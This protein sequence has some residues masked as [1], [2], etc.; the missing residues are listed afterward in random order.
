MTEIKHNRELGNPFPGL[1]PFESHEAH[2]FFGRDGQSDQLLGKLS[3]TRFVAVIGTSGSGKS[4]LVRAG[5]LPALY[6]GITVTG[7]DWHVGVLRPGGDPM[8]NLARSLISPHRIKSDSRQVNNE[9]DLGVC[10][11][12]LRRSSTG[13]IEARNWLKTVMEASPANM[14]I[15]VDQ[16]EELFRYKREA[17]DNQTEDV[18]AAFVKLLL[19]AVEH[20]DVPIYVVLTMRSEYL[21]DCAQFLGLPEAIN[22]GQYLIPRLTRDERRAAIEGPIGVCHSKISQFLVNR[23]LND[24]GDNPK[25]LPILQHALM[26]TWDQWV[27]TDQDTIDLNNYY[28]IGGMTSALSRYGDEVFALFSD[29]RQR[30]I[31]RKLFTCLVERDQEGRVVR[32]PTSLHTICQIIHGDSAPESSEKEIFE[33]AREVIPVIETFRSPSVSF[34]TPPPHIKLEAEHLDIV[35]DISHESLIRGWEMLQGWA[36]SE[37]DSARIYRRLAES[38][39]M[40]AAG[41]AALYKGRDLRVA[42][43]WQEDFRPSR[44]WAVRYHPAFDKAM[45]FLRKSRRQRVITI[46]ATCIAIT[47][48]LI[49]I[50]A[51]IF[52]FDRQRNITRSEELAA[53][54]NDISQSDPQRGLQLAVEAVRTYETDNAVKALRQSLVEN[55]SRVPIPPIRDGTRRYGVVSGTFSPNGKFVLTAN[56][57]GKAYI[58][59][60]GTEFGE[61]SQIG[62]IDPKL[63]F[64]TSASFNSGGDKIII[65]AGHAKKAVV[66]NFDQDTY[67]VGSQVADLRGHTGTVN[68]AAFSQDG[69]Y[70]ITAS[71]DGTARIWDLNQRNG[72]QVAV[73]EH[74]PRKQNDTLN[75]QT[76]QDTVWVKSAVF[77]PTDSKYILTASWDGTAR[78]WYWDGLS[79]TGREVLEPARHEG[80]VN[81]AAFSKDGKHIVT[82]GNDRKAKVMEWNQN[83]G[84]VG[85]VL[86]FIHDAPVLDAAFNP[87]DSQ[88]IITACA[89]KEAR[90]WNLSEDNNVAPIKGTSLWAHSDWVTGVSFNQEEHS[91][92]KQLIL[93]TGYD[94]TALVLR[95]IEKKEQL[96][97]YL[98]QALSPVLSV[99]FID[100]GKQF[101]TGSN[102]GSVRLWDVATMGGRPLLKPNPSVVALDAVFS[103]DG[104]RVALALNDGSV[105]WRNI[106]TGKTLI[107][108]AHSGAALSVALSFN[109]SRLASGG[110]D[111]TTKVWDVSDE[112]YNNSMIYRQGITVS[113][114][115]VA[116][117]SQNTH[118]VT[119]SSD[120]ATQLLD[121][122]TGS[123]TTWSQ[124]A[125]IQCVAFSPDGKS[126]VI[127]GNDGIILIIGVEGTRRQRM[128]GYDG[129]KP[130]PIFR[131]KFS[132][133]G[134]YL[135]TADYDS[136]R[137]WDVDTGKQLAKM[138]ETSIDRRF[139]EVSRDN[140]I[141]TNVNQQ[142]SNI[143]QI[144]SD[145]TSLRLI[146][147]LAFSLDDKYITIARA[148][149][150]PVHMFAWSYFSSATELLKKAETFLSR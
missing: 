34:L 24:A 110:R 45:D 39:D 135:A 49:M 117:N 106:D 13:L 83:T 10:E 52:F 12:I 97:R 113:V 131:A 85:K 43:D 4:S 60:I 36:D 62:V 122:Q 144:P 149:D 114:N 29:T 94:G 123:V 22:K 99:S 74:K 17:A 88:N 86:E 3:K 107:I 139:A 87:N 7:S 73:L 128:T 42:S 89:D 124:S 126:I 19:V 81:N 66:W 72:K 40:H 28:A 16:F 145:S 103:G 133:N 15:I 55:S 137:V 93:A 33:V 70:A 56:R 51:G 102:D 6:G 109:G 25:N 14:L 143:T 127:V 96:E 20:K 8:G 2:L 58:W 115:S 98:D 79:P 65:T 68:R 41:K 11:T 142:A 129:S 104:K 147:N 35:I 69:R 112:G 95:Y 76:V 48:V 118:V 38:A 77:S 136:V 108:P 30:E 31:A 90:L 150:R 1:R 64:I 82:A 5:L 32:R 18:A 37:A 91:P 61:P 75:E 101:L 120:G 9:I 132:H 53:Y 26:R 23:L 84:E 67:T 50:F 146:N 54:A 57:D 134:K 111:G 59:L 138:V 71:S 100:Y 47:L 130:V 80:G 44:A 92:A 105:I 78:L 121:L 27:K 119:G 21:G 63:G 140:P 46:A 116:F 148:D 125:P 141:F